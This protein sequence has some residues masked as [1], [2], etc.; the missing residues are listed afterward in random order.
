M[1]IEKLVIN[2]WQ[3]INKDSLHPTPA[4][5]PIL[6]RVL[7]FSRVINLVYK[8]EDIYTNSKTKFKDIINKVLVQPFKI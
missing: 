5:I 2:A 8:D 3:D 6:M 1:K 4:P 7:N